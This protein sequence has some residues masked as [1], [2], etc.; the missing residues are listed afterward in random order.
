MCRL[1]WRSGNG[2]GYIN[3]VKLHRTR[4]VLGLVTFGVSAIPVSPRPTQPGHPSVDWC[5]E[6]WRQFRSTLG[7]ETTSSA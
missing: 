1:V 4:L 2:I 5:S 3:K 7:K 6:Y